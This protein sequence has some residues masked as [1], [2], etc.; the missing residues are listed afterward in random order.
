MKREEV[1]I[2]IRE[3]FV[4]IFDNENLIINDDT[5]ATDIEGWDSLT[6]ISILT[7][8][9]DEFGVRF[10]MNEIIG[11]KNVGDMIDAIIKKM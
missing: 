9:Q 8:L 4:D 3:I 11:M 10:D 7:A 1:L 6:H 2:K 5:C